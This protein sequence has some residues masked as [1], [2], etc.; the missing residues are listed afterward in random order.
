MGHGTPVITGK[1]NDSAHAYQASLPKPLKYKDPKIFF[2]AYLKLN[3]GHTM[4][5]Y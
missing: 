2:L 3:K 4:S 1:S 5:G